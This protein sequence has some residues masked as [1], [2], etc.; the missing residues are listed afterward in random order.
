MGPTGE[1]D[2]SEGLVVI[3]KQGIWVKYVLVSVSFGIVRWLEEDVRSVVR[4][5]SSNLSGPIHKV[6]LKAGRLLGILDCDDNA[7]LEDCG[8]VQTSSK[9]V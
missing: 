3:S 2:R 5:C 9:F 1:Y 8:F 7:R 4:M 6:P